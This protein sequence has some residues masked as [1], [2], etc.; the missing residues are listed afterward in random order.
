[1]GPGAGGQ[2]PRAGCRLTGSTPVGYGELVDGVI[3]QLELP[4]LDDPLA[5]LHGR[6]RLVAGPPDDG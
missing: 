3:E 5:Y 6:Y 2:R 1:M 4:D